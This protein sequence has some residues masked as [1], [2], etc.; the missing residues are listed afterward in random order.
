MLGA[1]EQTRSEPVLLRIH[2]DVTRLTN[3]GR[4]T[5]YNEI[6]GGRLR[7]IKI[8]RAIRIRRDDLDRWLDLHTTG[9]NRPEAS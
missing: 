7:A 6:A 4:S 9:G 2:P 8:G 1:H 3:L 5:I